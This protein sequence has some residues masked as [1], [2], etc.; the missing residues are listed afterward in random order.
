MLS[1][2]PVL[3]RQFNELINGTSQW[4]QTNIKQS[5]S[6]ILLFGDMIKIKTF[7]SNVLKID[8]K[9]Y[10]DIGTYYIGYITI[11]KFGDCRNIHSVNLLYL[12]IH[13]ATGH[14]KEKKD[15]QYL[16]LDLT[17][18]YEE[19]WSG[20]KSEIQIVNSA[21][22]LFYE[23]NHARIGFNTDNDILLNKGLKVSRLTIIIRCVFQEGEKL[24]PQ[25]YLDECLYELQTL[26]ELDRIEESE[27][28]DLDKTDK[29][30]GCKICHYNHF[31]NGFKS[32]S[33]ICNRCDWGIKYFGNFA[34]IHVN[35][36]SYRVF[37]YNITE[38]DVNEFIKDFE[39]NDEF[40]T[41]LQYKRIDISEGIDIYKTNAPKECMLCHYWYFKD[42]RFK[43][44]PHLCNI[45]STRYISSESKRI[46]LLNVEGVD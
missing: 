10:K 35:D 40:E 37:M 27:G 39:T 21:K 28:I 4:N 45:C 6:N 17:D 43:F 11:K 24:Y 31:D 41:T 32:D 30:K 2:V 23:K 44:K 7:H 9:L 34:I 25:I 15:K 8:K 20:I 26:V 29:S 33:K 22:E 18:K 14:F 5:Q 16:I 36:S 13:S 3:K 1:L 38:E 19:V 46:E 12:I 42:V